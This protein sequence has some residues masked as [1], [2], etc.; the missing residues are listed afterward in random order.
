MP[1]MPMRRG[2]EPLPG[3]PGEVIA[4]RYKVLETAGKG[5][6]AKVVK[7][8]DLQT[9]TNVAVKILSP[10]Y[11]RDGQ[12]ELDVLQAIQR[13]DQSNEFKVCKLR[14]HFKVGGSTCFVFD[15]LGRSLKHAR[16]T[17]RCRE[18]RRT[19]TNMTKQLARALQYMHFDCRMVHTDLK[20][21][22]I[23]L[24]DPA[25]R[26][27]GDAWTIVDFGSASFYTEKPDEDLI[28][29]RPYRAPEVI[30]GGPWCYAADMWSFGC[31]LYEM[32]TG[33]VLFDVASDAQHMQCIERRCG[34]V[35]PWL[36]GTAEH[37]VR[38]QLFDGEGRLRPAVGKGPPLPFCDD[39]RDDPLF[40][41]LLRRLLHYDPVLRI[42][43]D[44]VLCHPFLES[45]DRVPRETGVLSRLPMSFYSSKWVKCPGASMRR[46]PLDQLLAE[47]IPPRSGSGGSERA[48]GRY[49]QG[50]RGSAENFRERERER[51][52]DREREREDRER[53]RDREL[54]HLEDK[55]RRMQGGGGGASGGRHMA[56]PAPSRAQAPSRAAYAAEESLRALSAADG[57]LYPQSRSGSGG[58]FHH[59]AASGRV[60]VEQRRGLAVPHRM[61]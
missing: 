21:E 34:P 15:L 7:A 43:A 53:E 59:P 12:F 61:L 25:A 6:F 50:R 49:E 46:L 54:R 42:R 51:E 31:I 1:V 10:E 37:R 47:E 19:L 52:R 24:D 45:A 33:R 44:E 28:S 22:N 55:F 30:I 58:H 18:S 56:P 16:A 26:G 20:P 38:P 60:P 36:A 11:E 35:P 13:G 48:N 8:R 9:N 39:I 32:Y 29:T 5:N 2:Y 3:G 40:V 41:D 57:V 23:L 27:S 4:G 17:V 14:T